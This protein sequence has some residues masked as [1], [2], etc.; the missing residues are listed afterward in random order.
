MMN[1]LRNVRNFVLSFAS[2]VFS[3]AAVVGLISA[4]ATGGN[5]LVS[6]LRRHTLKP[7]LQRRQCV[8][9]VLKKS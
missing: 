3:V 5:R 4:L 6:G 2:L 7:N 1:N 8:P 9:S